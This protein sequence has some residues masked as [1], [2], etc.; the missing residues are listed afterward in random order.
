MSFHFIKG[1]T[2]IEIPSPT[3]GDIRRV[4]D[5]AIRRRTMNGDL[6]VFSD[7]EWRVMIVHVY[8]FT[9]IKDT[10]AFPVIATLKTFFSDNSGLPITIINHLGNSY[11]G[12]ILT[13]AQEI[14]YT[15]PKCSQGLSIEFLQGNGV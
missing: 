6:K 8:Q 13:P 4:D 7:S 2:N 10:I 12:V 11:D 14:I 5:S 3:F 1:I 15:R 9:N